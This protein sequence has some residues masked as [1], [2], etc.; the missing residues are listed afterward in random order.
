MQRAP[1]SIRSQVASYLRKAIAAGA[2]QPGQAIIERQIS[3]ETTA[4]RGSVREAVRQLEAEGLLVAQQGRGTFVASL[5]VAEACQLYEVRAVLEG[6]AGWLF[7]LKASEEQLAE[8]ERIVEELAPL[9]DD[10][11]EMLRR[12]N[13]FY[14]IL[15]TGCENSELHRVIDTL[16]VRVTLAR[17]TSLARPGRPAESVEE[18][19]QIVAALRARSPERASQLLV[20]HIRN[21]AAAAVGEEAAVEMCTP[22]LATA[23]ETAGSKG[24]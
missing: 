23:E 16:H 11:A 12:K 17:A 6:L 15:F 8:M 13:E 10:P 22:L 14:D 2:L 7:A 20:S 19:R 21:A 5:S 1:A 9:V 4:S 24:A 3:E 18:L